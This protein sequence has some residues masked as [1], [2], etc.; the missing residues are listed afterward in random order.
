MSTPT[1]LPS[2]PSVAVSAQES[3]VAPPPAS[4]SVPAAEPTDISGS[5]SRIDVIDQAGAKHWKG[6]V[7]A[8]LVLGVGAAGYF[9]FRGEGEPVLE[10]GTEVVISDFVNTTGDPVFDGTLKQALAV[11]VAESPYL[12]VYP[13]DKMIET[14]ELM[15][16][17]PDER[18]TPEVA[19]EICQRRGVK[20]MLSGEVATLGS[21]FI[22]TLNATDCG[23]GELLVGQQVEAGSKEEV[24]GALGTAITRMR[25]D[26]GESLASV[27]KYDVPI[28]QATTP[29]LEALQAF[30]EGAEERIQGRDF[31]AIPFMQRAIELDPGF[32]LAHARLGTAY[33]N[34][35]QTLKAHEHWRKAYE[36]REGVSEP[37]R[38]YILAHYHADLLGD[39]RK[40]AEVYQQWSKTYPREW[41]TYNNLALIQGSLGELEKSLETSLKA[42]ELNPDH[43]FPHGNV[44]FSYVVLGRLEE[45][46][47][48]LA[49]MENRGFSGASQQFVRSFLESA[50]GNEAGFNEALDFFTGTPGEPNALRLKGGWVARHG[51][52]TELRAL[53]RR[54]EELATDLTGDPGV[55]TAKVNLAYRLMDLGYESEA[56][57]L[58]REA[59]QLARD[60]DTLSNA[61]AVLSASGDPGEARA[62]IDELDERWPQDT[63]VQ[64]A[65]IPESRARLALRAGDAVEAIDVLETARPFERAELDTI[66]LRGQAYLANGEPGKAVDEFQKLVALE[67]VFAIWTVHSLAH[68]WLGRAHLANGD[69]DAARAAYETFFDEMKSSDEGV[70]V[71]DKARSEYE[72]I[73]G[74]KG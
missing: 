16:R 57:E 11:K 61:S 63:I 53:A 30:S 72:T 48:A 60:V 42:L 54:E 47:A 19:R 46:R 50:A 4:V 44:A 37:E 18:I 66:R 10:E 13:Q 64:G 69:S 31:Q 3:A 36:L 8:V 49:E 29:V 74:V 45:A 56:A 12:D 71:V 35:G 24:L 73:P 26:L 58:A 52:A 2:Q 70:P 17:S 14:L 34:T 28:E 65:Q 25:G 15:Q 7:A 62:L 38:L 33:I 40:G 67:S 23:T 55:A 22:I 59:L 6:L 41:A 39:Q 32:A 20:S 27:E 5:T 68:L 21:N 43:A 9:A 1:A 51:R